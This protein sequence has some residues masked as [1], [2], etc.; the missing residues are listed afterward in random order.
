LGGRAYIAGAFEHPGRHLPEISLA[1]LHAEV[2]LGALADAGLAL[3]D[4]DGF[5]STPDAPGLGLISLADYLGLDRLVYTDTTETGGSAYVAHVGHAAMAIQVGLCSVVLVTMAGKFSSGL[6]MPSAYHEAP[7]LGFEIPFGTSIVAE[8]ALAARRHMY[9]FGTTSAQL[10]E[11]KVA[12][13]MNA[14]HNPNALL[15]KAVTVEQVLGSPMIADPLHKLDC[16]I[17]TDGGG[18]LVVVSED[19]A[20]SLDRHCIAIRGHATAIKGSFGGRNDLTD[21]ASVQSGGRAYEMAGVGPRDIDYVGLYDS[22]TI[23]VLEQLEDL[24]FCEKGKGGPFVESGALR[25]PDG[26]LPTNS[27]G[28]GLCNNHP[29]ARGG[30]PKMIEAVRQ[31]RGEATTEV[32][33]RDCRMALVN[34]IGGSI[35]TRMGSATLVLGSEAV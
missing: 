20:R 22:F 29:G 17:N 7:E 3:A 13:S 30:M 11:V 18:A 32:Q 10:A 16:C 27:D 1:E 24:G 31:L 14:R 15:R 34:G 35:G 21:T 9:E 5:L 28:G 6:P 2:A 19:V 4:V 25:S 33:V 12:A 26:S 8:Y 23:T